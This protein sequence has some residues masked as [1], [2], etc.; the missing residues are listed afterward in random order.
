LQIGNTM[1]KASAGLYMAELGD[2]HASAL[3]GWL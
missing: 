1:Q 3:L 2:A